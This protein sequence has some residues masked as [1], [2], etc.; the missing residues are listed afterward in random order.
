MPQQE[1]LHELAEFALKIRIGIVEEI[2][3][4]GVGHLGGSLSIADVLAVLY[5]G[6]MHVDPKTPKM[7]DRDK[8]FHLKVNETANGG[9]RRPQSTSLRFLCCPACMLQYLVISPG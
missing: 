6:V 4:R 5:G 2:K 8:L 7:E 1:S 3:A 9:R